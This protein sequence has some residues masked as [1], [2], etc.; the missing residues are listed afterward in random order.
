[1]VQIVH[2]QSFR[3]VVIVSKGRKNWCVGE[4]GAVNIVWLQEGSIFYLRSLKT[5][6]NDFGV[7]YKRIFEE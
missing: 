2:E 6:Q 1:M 3:R 5:L 4:V 7:L